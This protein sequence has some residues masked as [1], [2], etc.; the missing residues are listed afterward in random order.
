MHPM[1]LGTQVAFLERPEN[2][3]IAIVGSDHYIITESG[4][5]SGLK[6]YPVASPDIRALILFQNPFSHPSVMMRSEVLKRFG[7]SSKYRF[8]EDYT[9]WFRILERYEMANIPEPLTYYRLHT[10]NS[11]R[12][13][14]KEQLQMTAELIVD[15]LDKLRITYTSAELAIHVAI[16]SNYGPKYFNSPDRIGKLRRWIL[17]VLAGIQR[18]YHYSDDFIASMAQQVLEGCCGIYDPIETPEQEMAGVA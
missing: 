6:Q 16:I 7:Y 4:K 13:H 18:K 1:R 8:A 5:L 15:E 9:L 17:K 10:D 3:S 2:A 11:S 14:N 12:R